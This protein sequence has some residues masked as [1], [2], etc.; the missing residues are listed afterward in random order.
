MPYNPVLF[1]IA[2]S[3]KFQR[4]NHNHKII[5]V[6]D[7]KIF[8]EG[9][10]FVLSH[11]NGFEVIGEA[12]NGFIFLEMIKETRPDIV[13]MDISMPR[14]DGVTATIKA[15][16]RYPDLKIIALT[17]F[18]D[19]E[20]YNKMIKAGVWGFILKESGREELCRAL[21]AVI[22][23]EKY[24]SQKLLH[25]IILNSGISNQSNHPN[26]RKN[27]N[28]TLMESEVLKL[29]CEGLS[30]HEISEKL[31]L[32]IR[33]VESYKSGLMSKTGTNN[34]INLAV[35]AFKNNLIQN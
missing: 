23:G 15:I 16:E 25:S 27:S 11:L 2:G 22:S 18:C 8:R 4:M 26:S 30:I 13:L 21:N 3:L 6:D 31:S 24:Y 1:N 20:Y 9:L 14:I 29:I 33:S 10:S 12:P 32:S 7:H 17:M 34:M 35:F 5:I 28:L 19:T